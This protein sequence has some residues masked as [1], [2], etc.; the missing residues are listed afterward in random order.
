MIICP[1]DQFIA[2]SMTVGDK[3]DTKEAGVWLPSPKT[4]PAIKCESG[5]RRVD[6]IIHELKEKDG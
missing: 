6:F 1:H 2:F 3:G 5:T 4:S